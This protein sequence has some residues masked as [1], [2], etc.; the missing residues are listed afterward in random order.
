M[1]ISY[2]MGY[3]KTILLVYNIQTTFFYI[4]ILP[5]WNIH[6]MI[7]EK[8]DKPKNIYKARSYWIRHQISPSRKQYGVERPNQ[9]QCKT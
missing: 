7:C 9:S 5:I 8:K 2:Y 1:S 4:N 6:A 3:N